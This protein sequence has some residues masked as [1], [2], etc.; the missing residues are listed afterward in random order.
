MCFVKELIEA[1]CQVPLCRQ[2]PNYRVELWQG[3]LGVFIY[4]ILIYIYI[5]C[6]MRAGAAE[7][8]LMS[9]ITIQDL[10]G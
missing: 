8:M 6:R 3:S 10:D 7:R 2:K 4:Y 1:G 9:D 5:G